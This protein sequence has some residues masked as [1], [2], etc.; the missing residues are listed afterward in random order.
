[1]RCRALVICVLLNAVLLGL[2]FLRTQATRFKADPGT[3]FICIVDR[4]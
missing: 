2:R 1:M 4:R 3:A